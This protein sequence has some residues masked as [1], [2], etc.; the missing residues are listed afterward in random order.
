[1]NASEALDSI[2]RHARLPVE[3]LQ[4]VRLTGEDPVLPSSFAVGAAAQ[5]TMAAAALAACELGHLRGAGRQQVAV[6]MRHAALD[7]TGWFS[8]DGRVPD[9]WDTFSGPYRCADGWVRIHA[10]FAHHRDEA[11]RLMKL[12]P[13]TAKR[14]DAEAVMAAWRALDFEDA[15]AAQGL[16]ASAL[17]RFDQWDASPQGQAIAAQPLFT[18][19]RI[20]DA[21]PLALAPLREDQRPLEGVRA[22]DLTRILAGPVGGRALAAYGADVML[23]N[24][25]HLPNIESIAETSR[26]KLSAHVDLRTES[27][28][29]ALRQLAAQAHVFVQGYRPGG[30]AALG[31]GPAELARLS[32]GIV[33]V[34]L[35]AYGTQ[36]PWAHRRGFDS[37]VQTAMG[38]N[39]AEGEAAGDGQPKPLP[40]QIL[41]E[42]TGYLIACGA[43]AA[44]WRQQQ[45]GGSWHVQVSLAQTGHWLRG[46]G[47]VSGGLSIARPDLKPYLETSASGFG[48]LT[49]L[50]HGAQ[51]S[52]T[53]AAW[54]R[55][56]M[57]PGSHVPAWPGF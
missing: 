1:M 18:I 19:E 39:H 21:P 14:A 34:S 52:R 13:A 31:F 47:R 55:P 36:G 26:G 42:G 43:A 41:D 20:G 57:P 24:S 48:E 23:V 10:N 25:P 38:F 32:P 4:Q 6:D 28:H 49:A 16:V 50:R 12:D 27:G 7:C 5:S 53:P 8:L 9:L 11:L 22:L 35:T 29:A 51:L 33:C 54:P 56:S 37:L 15:A 44:L 40:M 17:R 3:A 2:W 45:E 46:L 30:I